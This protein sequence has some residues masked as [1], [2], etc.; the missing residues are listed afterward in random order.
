[1]RFDTSQASSLVDR[2]TTNIL[3]EPAEP[4]VLA[5][6]PETAAELP[7]AIPAP[8]ELLPVLPLP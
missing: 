6:A 7:E 8:P 5:A 1:M 3:A 2:L 4:L